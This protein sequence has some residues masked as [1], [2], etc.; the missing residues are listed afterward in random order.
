MVVM[1][2]EVTYEERLFPNFQPSSPAG[3]TSTFSKHVDNP[4][5]YNMAE[6]ESIPLLQQHQPLLRQFAASVVDGVSD[7]RAAPHIQ[8]VFQSLFGSSYLG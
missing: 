4:R 5:Q 2:D 3:K 1:V 7:T 6:S 8:Q